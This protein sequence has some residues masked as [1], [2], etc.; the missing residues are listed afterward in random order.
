MLEERK[1]CKTRDDFLFERWPRT[2]QPF[3]GVFHTASI[4]MVLLQ[5]PRNDGYCY[6][7]AGIAICAN[8]ND[9]L[10][11]EDIPHAG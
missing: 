2:S 3:S 11:N 10:D 5:Q 1:E 9:L 7:Q 6:G 4:K 8:A